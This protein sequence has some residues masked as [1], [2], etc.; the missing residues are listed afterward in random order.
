[1]R[2]VL[3]LPQLARAFGDLRPRWVV[4]IVVGTSVATHM[5]LAARSVL[6]GA[7]LAVPPFDQMGGGLRD[8]GIVYRNLF[9][10]PEA[11]EP[12]LRMLALWVLVLLGLAVFASYLE[13]RHL[14]AGVLI[15]LSY[16]IATLVTLAATLPA[17]WILFGGWGPAA[18]AFVPP[19][20][21]G[22]S[23][24]LVARGTR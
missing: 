6:E 18:V 16:C 12:T 19:L 21:L 23:G 17:V 14:L 7:H 2:P 22:L 20:V 4:W 13:G 1:M 10:Y 5:I 24:L 15:F 8:W 3:N 9:F 11:R